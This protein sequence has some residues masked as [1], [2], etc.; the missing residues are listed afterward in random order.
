MNY[1]AI[2]ILHISDKLVIER[3]GCTVQPIFSS[4]HKFYCYLI[5]QQNMGNS[6][7]YYCTRNRGELMNKSHYTKNQV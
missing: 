5:S 2:D 6:E 7:K 1:Q 3:L 4:F